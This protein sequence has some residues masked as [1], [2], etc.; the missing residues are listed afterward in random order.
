MPK[1]VHS[2]PLSTRRFLFFSFFF[3]SFFFFF[4]FGAKIS[5]LDWLPPEDS[6][7]SLDVLL[8]L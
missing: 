4:F 6:S 3:F 1:V 2:L 7:L 5:P 8:L